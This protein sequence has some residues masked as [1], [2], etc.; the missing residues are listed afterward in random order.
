MRAD[1][2]R[3]RL[4][5]SG[6]QHQDAPF[7]LLLP[8]IL[9]EFLVVGQRGAVELHPGRLGN[10]IRGAPV[11]P[12]ETLPAW[13]ELPLVASVAGADARGRIR[14]ALAARGYSETLDFVVA[15]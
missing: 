13:R 5:R 15:P 9:D 3:Q 14:A 2:V 4:V 10:R 1:D 6:G 7:G 8:Q 12:P 11:I